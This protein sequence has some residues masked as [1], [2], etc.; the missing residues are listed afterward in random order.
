[1]LSKIKFLN[2]C[3]YLNNKIF[4]KNYIEEISYLQFIDLLIDVYDT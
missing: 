3:L 1:M 2:Y 4:M